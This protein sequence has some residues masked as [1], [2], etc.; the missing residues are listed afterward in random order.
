MN[1]FRGW[2]KFIL[3]YINNEVFNSEIQTEDEVLNAVKNLIKNIDKL[4]YTSGSIFTDLFILK[5]SLINKI[6]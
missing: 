4:K 5:F 6:K 1:V 2:N 3:I